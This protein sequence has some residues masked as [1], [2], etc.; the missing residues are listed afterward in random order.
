[1][2]INTPMKEAARWLPCIINMVSKSGSKFG[3]SGYVRSNRTS[4]DVGTL[5]FDWLSWQADAKSHSASALEGVRCRNTFSQS[6]QETMVRQ[7]NAPPS[8]V[9]MRRHSPMHVRSF[10]SSCKASPTL[11]EVRW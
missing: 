5:S 9:T 11:I 8:C 7:Q 4:G 6:E 3:N 2:L 10:E 1:V